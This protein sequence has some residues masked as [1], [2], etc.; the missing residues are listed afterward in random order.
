[1][2]FLD[3]HEGIAE[4]FDDSNSI[5]TERRH[6]S[7]ARHWFL[8]NRAGRHPYEPPVPPLPRAVSCVLCR[9]EM[10]S[11]KALAAHIWGA[12]MLDRANAVTCCVCREAFI[13]SGAFL[14]HFV[15]RHRDVH[16]AASRI[17]LRLG[18]ARRA[19]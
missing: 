6:G 5:M 9:K 13:G 4:L 8:L 3:L 16:I 14:T 17:N 19:A 10:A 1:M 18:R 2:A 7:D 11:D 12:H 15:A